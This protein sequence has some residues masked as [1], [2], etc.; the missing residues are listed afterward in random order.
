MRL[1]PSKMFLFAS[2]LAALLYLSDAQLSPTA[3]SNDSCWR[4]SASARPKSE[5]M[6]ET[7]AVAVLRCFL[8]CGPGS[9]PGAEVYYVCGTVWDD[10]VIVSGKMCA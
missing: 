5:G 3:C 1:G 6:T 2:A 4:P 7:A 9:V 8:Q 10:H